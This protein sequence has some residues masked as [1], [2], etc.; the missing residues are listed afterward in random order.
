[1]KLDRL[2]KERAL[3]LMGQDFWRSEREAA[4]ER[5]AEPKPDAGAKTKPETVL[6]ADWQGHSWEAYMA[7]LRRKYEG[8]SEH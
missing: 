1:M 5:E 3:T 7:E 6:E 4:V 2:Y 8:V